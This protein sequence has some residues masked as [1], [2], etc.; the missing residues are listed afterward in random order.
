MIQKEF[1]KHLD[2]TDSILNKFKNQTNIIM[3]KKISDGGFFGESVYDEKI[4]NDFEKAIVLE[5]KG[6]SWKTNRNWYITNLA[7]L[8]IGR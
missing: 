8:T 3:Y 2:E 1:N 7:I 6:W 5:Q 4:V